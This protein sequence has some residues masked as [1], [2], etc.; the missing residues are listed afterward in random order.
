MNH[1]DCKSVRSQSNRSP[2]VSR[3]QSRRGR[4]CARRSVLHT[5]KVF[6]ELVFLIVWRE[7]LLSVPWTNKSQR[8]CAQTYLYAEREIIPQDLEE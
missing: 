6:L 2:R 4:G 5:E 7:E 1:P 3:T 8:G